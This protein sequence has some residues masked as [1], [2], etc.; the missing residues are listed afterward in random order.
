MKVLGPDQR[1]SV[2][3]AIRAVT[4]DAAYQVML[5][6]KVG[7]LEVGKYADFVILEQNP[8]RTDP[9]MIRHIKAKETWIDGKRVRLQ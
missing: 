6:D 4:I 7:S 9:L 8:R 3:D 2:D 5:D 1:I